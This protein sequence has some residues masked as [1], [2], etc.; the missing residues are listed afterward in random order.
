MPPQPFPTG[1][2]V[3]ARTVLVVDDTPD[4]RSTLARLLRLHGY[5]PVTAGGGAAALAAVEADAPDLMVLDLTMADM[6]GFDVLRRLRG[7]PRHRHLPIVMFTAVSDARLAAE[8]RR[9]G[10]SDYVVK[11]SAAA[12]DLLDRI[13]HLLTPDP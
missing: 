11:G 8:A 13:A 5:R 12:A 9:L 6:H 2:A 1:V 3:I 7:D 10:A 4:T